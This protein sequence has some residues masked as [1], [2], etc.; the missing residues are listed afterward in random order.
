VAYL[1]NKQSGQATLSG[2]SVTPT[3]STY[4]L[5][6]SIL[7]WKFRG[8]YNTPTS[9]QVSGRKLST[10]QIQF[11]RNGTDG[12]TVIVEWE[13]LEFDTDVTVQDLSSS[14]SEGTTHNITVSS[15]TVSQSFL[16]SG[17][18]EGKSGSAFS[19]DDF[20]R[21][22]LTSSTNVERYLY[23]AFDAT[24]YA[25]LVDYADCSVQ[26]FN[27]DNQS[28]AQWPQTI[29]SVTTTKVALWASGTI[30]DAGG[31]D[32]IYETY[33]NTST[34]VRGYAYTGATVND[35][36]VQVVE[37]TDNTTTQH[38]DYSVSSGTATDNIT[39]SN[40]D[41]D[42]SCSMLQGCTSLGMSH[43]TSIDTDDDTRTTFFTTLLTSG[44]NL[45]VQ[46]TDGTG[47][48]AY[49]GYCVITFEEEAAVGENAPFFGC[50]F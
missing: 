33:L 24:F 31:M 34:E 28:G 4:T 42:L 8:G 35:L 18:V 47:V 2:T 29:S 46:R 7:I 41:T 1:L 3:V 22:A 20:A 37:F 10:T 13:L 12:D 36:H 23:E 25:Q 19:A 44:T 32:D 43:G 14:Y 11:T 39:I 27:R 40:I 26:R 49:I 16:I 30:R 48:T 50:N 17:G 45:Q 21:W 6:R 38:A 9:G 5:A 15:V